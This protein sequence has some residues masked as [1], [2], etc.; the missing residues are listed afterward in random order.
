[1]LP[2]IAVAI[3]R[4]PATRSQLTRPRVT[5]AFGASGAGWFQPNQTEPAAGTVLEG[6][7]QFPAADTRTVKDRLLPLHAV[8]IDG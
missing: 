8:R 3:V 6:G 4:P 1:M 7:E 2:T 5:S